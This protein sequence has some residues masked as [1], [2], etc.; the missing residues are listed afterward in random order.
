[1]IYL[2]HAASTPIDSKAFHVL[3]NSLKEDCANPQAAHKL[4][5]LLDK[6]IEHCR[7]YFLDVLNAKEGL[8][9][10]TSSA[11]ES[12]NM[13]IRGWRGDSS[14]NLFYCPADHPSVTVPCENRNDIKINNIPLNS[15]AIDINTFLKR[16]DNKTTLIVLTHINSAG[17]HINPISFLAKKIKEKN[18]SIWIHVDAAQSYGKYP[19]DVENLD[20]I[21]ISSHKIGGPKGIAGLYMRA[22]TFFDPLILGGGQEKGWRASTQA[23]PL[24]LSFTE[25]SRQIFTDMESKRQYV[26]E[27]NDM[28]RGLLLDIPQIS[29]PFTDTSFYILSFILPRISSDILL[30]QLEQKGIFL[31]STSA[32]SSRIKGKNPTLSALGLD[33][34]LHKFVLR[35]SF[36]HQTTKEEIKTFGKEL[37]I[38]YEKNRK[39]LN[40]A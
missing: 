30:R 13:V 27:L 28:A 10:F 18:P 36:S 34:S 26:Q 20:S 14:Q 35:L 8:F 32:C 21:A 19:L 38:L 31:S 39:I 11:S 22:N 29:L 6:R 15:G 37:K 17:G 16:I 24:I 33:E 2:D 3:V 25:A 23:T 7:S 9:I 1:M 40:H 5:R 12:N 4:G